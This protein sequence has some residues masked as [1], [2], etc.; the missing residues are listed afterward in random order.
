MSRVLTDMQRAF[1][2][3]LFSDECK[4]N[5]TLAKRMAGY[6]DSVSA[7]TVMRGLSEEIT[8]VT[9]RY[10]SQHGP[11]AAMAMVESLGM[12]GPVPP[13]SREKM[14]AAREI[15]DR[16]VGVVKTD[17]LE[18]EGVKAG[19]VFLPPKDPEQDIDD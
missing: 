17:R 6:S 4:G 8:E 3:H 11:A 9:R 10:L 14:A 1:I 19:I 18:V 12:D 13:D 7:T 5:P 16:G 2:E 15:L